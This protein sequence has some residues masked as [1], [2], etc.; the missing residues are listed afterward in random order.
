MSGVCVPL[1][2]SS[3][4]ASINRNNDLFEAKICRAVRGNSYLFMECDGSLL[5]LHEPEVFESILHPCYLFP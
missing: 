1:L 4:G 2:A 5:C 3:D